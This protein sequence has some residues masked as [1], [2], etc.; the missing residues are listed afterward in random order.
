MDK[1]FGMVIARAPPWSRQ[2]VILRNTPFSITN[3]SDAQVVVRMTLAALAHSARGKSWKEAREA[4]ASEIAAGKVSPN[5]PPAAMFVQAG[6]EKFKSAL[7]AAIP[8]YK[9]LKELKGMK[10]Y[11]EELR[12]R[13][14]T[15][16]TLH[17]IKHW[18][19]QY[20]K[21]AE[22]VERTVGALA[23]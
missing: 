3:P 15:R 1:A 2:P 11:Y 14:R 5:I 8:G 21:F 22:V 9:M 20:P 23:K 4:L 10:E 13:T 7:E 19:A 17:D 18:K 16:R 6:K 12:K